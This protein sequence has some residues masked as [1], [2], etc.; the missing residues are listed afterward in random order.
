MYRNINHTKKRET[1]FMFFREQNKVTL[2]NIYLNST[3]FNLVCL[4]FKTALPLQ[5]ML[6][7]TS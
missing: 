6:S 3:E 5:D 1:S 4:T 2:R 7:F